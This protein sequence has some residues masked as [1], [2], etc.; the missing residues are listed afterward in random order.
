MSRE[1]GIIVRV[2]GERALVRINRSASCEGCQ[3]AGACHI[4]DGRNEMEAEAYNIAGAKEGDRVLLE[5]NPSVAVKVAFIIYLLPVIALIA[6]AI[7][8]QKLGPDYSLSADT[9]AILFGLSALVAVSIPIKILAKKLS[10][11]KEYIP[12]IVQI[13]H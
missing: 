2:T 5:I 7:V 11:N 6:G 4:L 12:H 8:G 9:S 10:R 1:E 13:I 3:S